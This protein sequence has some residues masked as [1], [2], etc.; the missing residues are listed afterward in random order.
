MTQES[1]QFSGVV[2]FVS[3]R[4]STAYFT[5]GR[6]TPLPGIPSPKPWKRDGMNESMSAFLTGPKAFL[7]SGVNLCMNANSCWSDFYSLA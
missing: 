2:F 4:A 1:V 3:R 5:G 6:V 7:V